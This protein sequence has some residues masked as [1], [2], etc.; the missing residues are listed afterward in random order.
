MNR[1][2]NPL[3]FVLL[4]T[5]LTIIG[6]PPTGLAAQ[7]AIT[8]E[9]ADLVGA[10]A[11][12]PAP[13]YQRWIREFARASDAFTI[14]YDAIGSGDGIDRFMAEKVDFGASDAAMRDEQIARV[15]RGVKLIPATA[16]II[17]LAYHL[18]GSGALRLSREVYSDI[19]LGKIRSWD[20]PRIQA[21]NPDRRLPKLTIVTITRSDASGTTWAFT[22][23]LNAV[24]ESWRNVGPGV[25]KKIDWPA[26]SMSSRY[27]EGVAARIKYSQGSIGYVEYGIAK[28]SG[29][30][31]ASL[32]NRAGD[33]VTPSDTSGTVTLAN[34]SVRMPPNLRLF[35]PDPDGR[36]SYPIVTYTWLLVYRTYADP[37][38]A[39]KV[40]RF[41]RWGLSEG[42]KFAPEYG[43]APLPQP[44]AAL[45]L[46]ALADVR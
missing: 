42:Q 40:K 17:A 19:F 8:A 33:Y 18:P 26:N 37:D 31:M 27:N 5:V 39:D 22:N 34:T 4:L 30:S 23:H 38:K 36:N 3:L 9:T 25:G 14:F 45:A 44:V 20:D 7:P 41:L 29:L 21:L 12:F 43:Y 10:G 13:L 16:G 6:T 28:R 15:A 35:I 24:S 2:S 46:D 11:T 32:E 1:R